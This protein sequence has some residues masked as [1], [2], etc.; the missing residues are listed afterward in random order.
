MENPEQIL[1]RLSELYVT[2]RQRYI[3]CLPQ[4]KIITP[5]TKDGNYCRLTDGVIR[6]HLEHAYAVGIFAGE[7]GSKFICFD[8]DDGDRNTV[9]KIMD[10]LCALGFPKNRIYVSYSGGKGYH[11]ELFFEGIV[12][13]ELLKRLYT[14]VVTEGG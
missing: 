5:K 2:Y 9:K 3:L 10:V 7:W 13:T 1:R 12:S 4:G 11:V 8:V 14:H 6:K